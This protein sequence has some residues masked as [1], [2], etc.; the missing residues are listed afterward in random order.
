MVGYSYRGRLLRR[1]VPGRKRNDRNSR[2]DCRSYGGRY[3]VDWGAT[4][5]QATQSTKLAR[6]IE[7][8]VSMKSGS[9]K[10]REHRIILGMLVAS[11]EVA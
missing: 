1:A 2:A 10:S 7:K 9:A 4:P 5:F 8:N 3:T 11:I 6:A